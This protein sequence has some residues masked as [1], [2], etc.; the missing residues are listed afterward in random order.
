VDC[1]AFA[2]CGTVS[3]VLVVVGWEWKW[4]WFVGLSIKENEKVR[5]AQK[6][7]W[8]LLGSVRDICAW[9]T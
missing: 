3:V 4:K 9:E 7:G 5:A 6:T 8:W 1:I 2:F